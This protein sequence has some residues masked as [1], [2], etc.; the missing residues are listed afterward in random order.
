[1]DQSLLQHFGEYGRGASVES[2]IALPGFRDRHPT[3]AAFYAADPRRWP[4]REI[5]LGLR[6]RG[7]GRSTYR[8]AFVEATGELYLFEH[9]RADGGGGV[10]LVHERRFT[11]RTLAET[12]NGWERVCGTVG[13]L[14]WLVACANGL[15]LRL[16]L[17][18]SGRG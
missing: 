9:V 13:S 15:D 14:D 17:Q 16:P 18:T 5:D 10:V 11:D 6:W 3:L 2:A 4:S 8:A 1:M 12:F 7:A